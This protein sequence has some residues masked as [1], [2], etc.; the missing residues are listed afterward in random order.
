MQPDPNTTLPLFVYESLIDPVHCAKVLARFAASVPAV[1]NEYVRATTFARSATASGD[2]HH[3]QTGVIRGL[4]LSRVGGSEGQRLCGFHL[5]KQRRGDVQSVEGPDRRCRISRS[6][7]SATRAPSSTRSQYCRSAS[8]C[9]TI[10]SK[11]ARVTSLARNRQAIADT[12][13]ITDDRLR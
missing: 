1:L 9:A 6:A 11:W 8:M 4:A 3:F 13:A 5:E 7:P 2:P 12:G 10:P